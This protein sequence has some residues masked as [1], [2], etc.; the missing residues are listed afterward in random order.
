MNLVFALLAR[1]LPRRRTTGAFPKRCPSDMRVPVLL[2]SAT[3]ADRVSIERLL[4]GTRYLPVS[5]A[6]PDH[7]AK[8]L[9]KVVFPIVLF[10][11][12]AG[13]GRQ[14]P[15]SRLTGGW[16]APAILLISEAGELPC[17]KERACC[18]A[19]DVVIRPFEAR[20][21][22]PIL[23]LAYTDWMAGLVKGREPCRGRAFAG[24]TRE[25]PP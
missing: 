16:R 3:E 12:F 11:P 21:V 8:L 23:D 9:S 22:V 20:D 18:V 24:A 15:I 1:L 2:V 25:V 17:C 5:A 7:A 14:I 19:F 4:S 10:D 13:K 6:C